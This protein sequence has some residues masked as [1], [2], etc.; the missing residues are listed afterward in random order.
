MLT[1]ILESPKRESCYLLSTSCYF[2][3]LAGENCKCIL[4]TGDIA[5]TLR[6][7][8]ADDNPELL[9]QLLITLSPQCEVIATATDGR[10]ALDSIRKL[11]PDVAVVDLKMPNL[12]GIELTKKAIC[13]PPHAAVV[14][15]SVESDPEIIEHALNAGALGY[16]LK[17]QIASDLI[18]AV[19]SAAAGRRFVSRTSSCRR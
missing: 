17:S 6:V 5:V 16:V 18:P 2:G 9:S 19:N 10:S 8:V 1:A 11:R 15:C 3:V 13:R 14:I 4:S 7:V 12:N